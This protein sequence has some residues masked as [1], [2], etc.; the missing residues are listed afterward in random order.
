VKVA[1]GWVTPLTSGD[2]ALTAAGDAGADAANTIYKIG[3][4]NENE[5]FLIENRQPAGYDQG[6]YLGLGSFGS[7]GLAVYHIDDSQYGN[8]TDFH[9]RVDLEEADGNENYNGT[10][11]TDL[12]Y[13]GNNEAFSE[14]SRPSSQL[15]SALPSGVTL[16]HFSPAGEVMTA[17]V[18]AGAPVEATLV[19][20]S[21]GMTVETRTPT[22]Q[23]L[24]GICCKSNL[25]SVSD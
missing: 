1:R 4:R 24:I 11:V 3:T 14:T 22:Y 15:Y 17:S 8:A 10:E 25:G 9:R 18:V 23:A 7:G 21:S 5:Y 6:L 16:S 19:A 2:I 20:P 13:L 12:W